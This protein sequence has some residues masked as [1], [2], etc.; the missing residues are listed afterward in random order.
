MF[1]RRHAPTPEEHR[2]EEMNMHGG[3]RVIGFRIQLIVEPDEN[4]FHAYCPALKG[5]H[6][7]GETERKALLNAK[8]A[9][10]A[11]LQSSMKHEDPIPVGIL[12]HGDIADSS[13]TPTERATYHMQDLKVACAI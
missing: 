8:D 6:T 7:Y 13:H 10:A 9:A 12:I 3:K 5:L 1:L 2:N 11:Y 4:G